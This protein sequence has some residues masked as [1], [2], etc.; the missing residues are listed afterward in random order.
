[1][2]AVV[3]QATAMNETTQSEAI[4]PRWYLMRVRGQSRWML[5]CTTDEVHDTP[6]HELRGPY[7]NCQQAMEAAA[8]VARDTTPPDSPPFN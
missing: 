3:K 5:I 4:A 7:R 2:H 6:Q 8:T 1:M